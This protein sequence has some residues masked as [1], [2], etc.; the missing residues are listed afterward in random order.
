MEI[1]KRFV[2]ALE[3][4]EKTPNVRHLLAIAAATGCELQWRNKRGKI[5]TIREISAI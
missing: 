4:G 3:R 2:V 1:T 5:T